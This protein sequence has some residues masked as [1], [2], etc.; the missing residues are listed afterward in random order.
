MFASRRHDTHFKASRSARKIVEEIP[1]RTHGY[2]LV[3]QCDII[4]MRDIMIL[5]VF[6]FFNDTVPIVTD[7]LYLRRYIRYGFA[8]LVNSNQRNGHLFP[9]VNVILV[10]PDT[11]EYRLSI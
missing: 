4:F 11:V 2:H 1:A 9:G 10:H 8:M 7:D 6:I 5:P 3:E